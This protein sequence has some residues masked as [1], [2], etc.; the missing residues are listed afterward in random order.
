ME[1]KWKNSQKLSTKYNSFY[2]FTRSGKKTVFL[3]AIAHRHRTANRQYY[4]ELAMT[5]K[6]WSKLVRMSRWNRMTHSN[7][8]F[9]LHPS[10]LGFSGVLIRW[11]QQTRDNDVRTFFVYLGWAK[12]AYLRCRQKRTSTN[13]VHRYGLLIYTV[14]IRRCTVLCEDEALANLQMR[15]RHLIDW[16]SY[17]AIVHPNMKKYSNKSKED[18]GDEEGEKAVFQ[19]IFV[20]FVSCNFMQFLDFKLGSVARLE[21]KLVFLKKPRSMNEKSLGYWSN[22]WIKFWLSLYTSSV[23]FYRSSL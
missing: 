11:M 19:Q 6:T 9:P 5:V 18:E 3:C 4:D 12:G 2:Y 23:L 15:N 10:L 14:L 21:K 1:S 20:S 7:F 17:I 8:R 13:L 16:V 22:I